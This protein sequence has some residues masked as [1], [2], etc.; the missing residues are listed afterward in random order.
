MSSAARAAFVGALAL[1]VAAEA[2][3]SGRGTARG[4][5][6]A[7]QAAEG[8]RLYAVHCAMCHGA[9]LEGTVETPQLVGKFMAEWAGRPLGDLFDYIS[10]AMPQHAPGSLPP[11]DNARIIAFLL[12]ANGAPEGERALPAEEAALRRIDFDAAPL[13]R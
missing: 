9:R 10:R 5:Y 13:P 1:L 11:R 7:E 2:P 8:A 12:Q 4:V 6:T 3:L